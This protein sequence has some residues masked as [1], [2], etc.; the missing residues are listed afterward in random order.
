MMAWGVEPRV[1]FL[2]VEFLDVA[3]RM[4]AQARMI[5][6]GGAGETRGAGAG[7]GLAAG[8]GTEAGSAYGTAPDGRR[9]I[10]KAVLREAFEG[11]LPDEILWRQKERFSD[12]V[13]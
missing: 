6:K 7:V 10:E 9:A 8:A 11:Y 12:G 5:V 4:D 2:D 1:P 3:M 13:G